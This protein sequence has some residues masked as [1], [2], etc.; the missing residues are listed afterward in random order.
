MSDIAGAVWNFVN[1]FVSGQWLRPA[2]DWVKSGIDYII[3]SIYYLLMQVYKFMYNSFVGFYNWIV[4][5]LEWIYNSIRPH[6]TNIITLWMTYYGI[7]K[8]IGSESMSVKNKVIGLF[9]TP[10]LSYIASEILA[11]FLPNA[12]SLPR[13]PYIHMDLI[14][15]ETCVH[16]QYVDEVVN[17]SRGIIEQLLHNQIMEENVYI[18]LRLLTVVE[19]SRHNQIWSENVFIGSQP[20]IISESCLHNQVTDESFGT[21]TV[22]RIDEGYSH[23]QVADEIVDIHYPV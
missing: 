3:N 14:I 18:G 17:I 6:L 15:D 5:G 1:Y 9:A 16:S 19:A 11:S 23:S 4:G 7:R 2:V 13:A 20:L 12:V 22:V 10:F 21:L 8:I